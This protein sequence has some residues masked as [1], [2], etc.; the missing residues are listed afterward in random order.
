MR[1]FLFI[2]GIEKKMVRDYAIAAIAIGG[3]A[4]FAAQGLVSVVGAMSTPDVP[5]ISA[6]GANGSVKT[7]TVTRSVLDDQMATG[8]IQSL[9]QIKLDPCKK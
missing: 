1:D 4:Y 8:S 5:K 6:A 3:L 7:Y 2:L 9:N